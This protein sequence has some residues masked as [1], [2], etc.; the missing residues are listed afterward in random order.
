[1][2]VWA[3]SIQREA[4]VG[5]RMGAPK[6]RNS[7]KVYCRIVVKL[8][9]SGPVSGPAE[10]PQSV[11]VCVAGSGALFSC[12]RCEIASVAIGAVIPGGTWNHPEYFACHPELFLGVLGIGLTPTI[13]VD[14]ST[15]SPQRTRHLLVQWFIRQSSALHGGD[16]Q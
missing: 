9:V 2:P 14:K 10:T 5:P 15:R 4:K 11:V 8:I 3:G 1:M 6:Y 13:E 12:R 7:E 16:S